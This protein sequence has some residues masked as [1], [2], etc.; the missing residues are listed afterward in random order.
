MEADRADALHC[1]LLAGTGNGQTNADAL[2]GAVNEAQAVGGGTIYFP[3]GEYE[4]I[5]PIDSEDLRQCAAARE[6]ITDD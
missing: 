2:R 4:V 5:S 6:D 3:V 1:N